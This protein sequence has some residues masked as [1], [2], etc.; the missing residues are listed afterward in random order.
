ML[1]QVSLIDHKSV[2][3]RN[4]FLRNQRASYGFKNCPKS[5]N[6]AVS[7]KLVRAFVG[8]VMKRFVWRVPR[9]LKLLEDT[10]EEQPDKRPKRW[11]TLLSAHLNKEPLLLKQLTKL[12]TQNPTTSQTPTTKSNGWFSSNKLTPTTKIPTNVIPKIGGE[13]SED[14]RMTQ[15]A[16]NSLI[17]QM[18]VLTGELCPQ[19]GKIVNVFNQEMMPDLSCPGA[20]FGGKKNKNKSRRK[21][22]FKK[23]K[24]RRQT[25]KH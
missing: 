5:S 6:G 1:A 14:V 24:K 2:V 20:K 4:R 17:S 7:K 19:Q 15:Q 18:D 16:F 9:I 3:P 8:R 25:R 10:I 11:R 22:N 12:L 23:S 21:N 13:V